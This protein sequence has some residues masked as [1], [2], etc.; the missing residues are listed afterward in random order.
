MRDQDTT[1]GDSITI[2]GP[3][4]TLIV[5]PA[6]LAGEFRLPGTEGGRWRFDPLAH[7][8]VSDPAGNPVHW[9]VEEIGP[10]PG[11]E[12]A[13]EARMRASA[14]TYRLAVGLDS[15]TGDLLL[16]IAPLAEPETIGRIAFPGPLVPVDD[17]ISLLSLPLIRTNGVMTEPSPNDH[18]ATTIV[19]GAHSGLN[20]P[21]W[22]MAAATHSLVGIIETPDDAH[23]QLVKTVRQPLLVEPDWQSSLGYLRYPR[24]LRMVL[25]ADASYVSMALAYRQYVQR[26]GQFRSLAEKIDARPGVQQ[27]IGGPYFSMGY[28]PLSERKFRQVVIGLREIGYTNGIIGPIDHIQ[29]DSGEWLNDYQPFIHAP[30]FSGIAAEQGFVAFCWLYLE[31]ILRWDPYFD[32][33][34][35]LTGKDGN[36]VEGWFN[37]DY[38]YAQICTRVL[39]EQ[40]TQLRDRISSFDALHFDT[41]TAKDLV[42]CWHP[43]HPMTRSQD[44]ESRH[45]RLAEVASWNPI[46]GAE[47]GYDWAFDV[48]DFCSNNPRADLSIHLP[49]SFSHIPLLGLVY[50]DSIVSY[51]WEYDPYNP[52][53]LGGDWS[54]QKLLYDAMAG[55]PPTVAPV[56]GYFPVI[57]RPAPPVASKWVMWEDEQTQRL[58]RDA[59]PI[60][61][62]HG[63]T[64]HQ[65]MINHERLSTDGAI[66]RTVYADGTTV[67][68]NQ[69]EEPWS[70]A[71]TT[72]PAHDYRIV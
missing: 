41:T 7:L 60:A 51:C 49:G 52:S 55:N 37:R 35:L 4:G 12:F 46:I 16:E 26:T 14:N 53:Y 31:D 28:L 54:R 48:M 17:D 22:G 56:F 27:V 18:W 66:T 70:D 24:R 30:H 33:E 44:R 59:L 61:Q 21:F 25:L 10:V 32:P 23:L 8:R 63:K 1:G 36:P 47:A 50:H 19:I 58:L 11:S 72:V 68:V 15:A 34:W 6:T 5:D 9:Q 13:V 29:W 71:G 20:M 69:G 65:P 67:L 39:L 45:A 2:G 40:H 3:A 42:E 57:S 64:A 38:E 62:L 43:D